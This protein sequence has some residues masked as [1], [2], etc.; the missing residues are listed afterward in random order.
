MKKSNERKAVEIFLWVILLILML[1]I[2][3]K[4]M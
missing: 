3:L 1:L 2:P 4:A